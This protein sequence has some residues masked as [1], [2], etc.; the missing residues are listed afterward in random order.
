MHI[1]AFSKQESKNGEVEKYTIV[2][3]KKS[4]K[5]EIEVDMNKVSTNSILS[6]S[7]NF[8]FSK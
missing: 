5:S 7:K 2:N 3:L 4:E 1:M 8:L 6:A